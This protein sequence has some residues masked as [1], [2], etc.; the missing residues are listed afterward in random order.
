MTGP[1][2]MAPTDELDQAAE[3]APQAAGGI[4]TMTPEQLLTAME[5]DAKRTELGVV[6][7]IVGEFPEPEGD[8][9][10]GNGSDDSGALAEPEDEGDEATRLLREALR[11]GLAVVQGDEPGTWVLRRS[12]SASIKPA[13]RLYARGKVSRLAALIRTSHSDGQSTPHECDLYLAADMIEEMQPKTPAEEILCEQIVLSHS[14]SVRLAAT[15]SGL[16]NGGSH[17]H[18]RATADAMLKTMNTT[19]RA[20]LALEQIRRGTS[21]SVRIEKAD[22]VNVSGGHQQVVNE[23][24]DERE[25]A[26]GGA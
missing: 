13:A 11:E 20:I 3:R 2:P 14:T 26:D 25:P 22:Q 9:D 15:A 18:A 23:N 17:E 6:E 12:R 21:A 5:L 24:T 1:E 16:E 4:E 19:R 7:S 10:A 8:A